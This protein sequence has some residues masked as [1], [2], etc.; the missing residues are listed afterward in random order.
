MKKP[1]HPS[2]CI[3]S[4]FPRMVLNQTTSQ[5]YKGSSHL[6]TPN[7]NIDWLC[8]LDTTYGLSDTIIDTHAFTC[9][10]Y[11]CYLVMFSIKHLVYLIGVWFGED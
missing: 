10:M 5:V 8:I 1:S 2:T 9:K 3:V 11:G 4:I 6:D 7:A